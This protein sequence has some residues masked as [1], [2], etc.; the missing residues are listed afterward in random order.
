MMPIFFSLYLQ[1]D[2]NVT[3]KNKQLRVTKKYVIM[4]IDSSKPYVQQ[5][6]KKM[7]N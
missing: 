5:V 4:F 2:K 1:H 6:F 3:W 7:R